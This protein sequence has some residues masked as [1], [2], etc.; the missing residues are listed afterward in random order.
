MG[1]RCC[2]WKTKSKA[3]RGGD[4][5][6]GEGGLLSAQPVLGGDSAFCQGASLH[7]SLT[8]ANVLVK[9]VASLCPGRGRLS[10]DGTSV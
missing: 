6:G 9:M 7:H 2:G 3:G 5:I 1:R 10:N 8:F 4:R